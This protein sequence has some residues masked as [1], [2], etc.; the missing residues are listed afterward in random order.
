MEV[1]CGGPSS[2]HYSQHRNSTGTGREN[3]PAKHLAG[4]TTFGR[5]AT[6]QFP[7]QRALRI[8]RCLKMIYVYR[9]CWFTEGSALDSMPYGAFQS[10]GVALRNALPPLVT[11]KR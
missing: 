10:G 1:G 5:S 9:R 3:C 11:K 6:A 7:R 4:A 2:L 8:T